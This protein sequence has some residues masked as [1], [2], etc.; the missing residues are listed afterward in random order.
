MSPKLKR[1]LWRAALILLALLAGSG[2]S[3]PV[4][5]SEPA[6]PPVQQ[7]GEPGL[8]PAP[9]AVPQAAGAEALLAVTTPGMTYQTYH[10]FLFQPIRPK[11]DWDYSF[12]TGTLHL[13][14]T[15]QG[16]QFVLPVFLPQGVDVRELT[17][18][19]RDNQPSSDLSMGL[20][21]VA[22]GDDAT[23]CLLWK[24]N[25]TGVNETGVVDRTLT[26][27]PIVTIDNANFSYFLVAV[28]PATGTGFG[29]VTAR[30]GY[31]TSAFL[32]EVSK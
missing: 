24:V 28:L 2:Y 19:F 26:G 3:G 13:L 6:A 31:A 30:I 25:S 27:T 23:G 5:A 7:G 32:P 18:F 14:S 20:C 21:R 9:G 12:S 16:G 22:L 15:I 1:V 10:S 8:L 29:L 4:Y 17:Y 11:T